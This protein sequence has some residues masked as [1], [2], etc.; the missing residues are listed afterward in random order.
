VKVIHNLNFTLKGKY[1]MKRTQKAMKLSLFGLAT[2]MAL[3]S[4]TTLSAETYQPETVQATTPS[5]K[6]P[7]EQA[8]AIIKPF[9][10]DAN[11]QVTKSFSA[12]CCEVADLLKDSQDPV[13]KELAKALSEVCKKSSNP[14]A[15]GLALKKY[16]QTIKQF[17]GDML[18][19]T[20]LYARLQ[21]ALKIK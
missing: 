14:M 8:L 3:V 21:T 20:V 6:T 9:F 19:G 12:I 2:L 1:I 11:Y 16:E 7:E 15:V 17:I 10:A 13:L 5:V 18:P 4:G